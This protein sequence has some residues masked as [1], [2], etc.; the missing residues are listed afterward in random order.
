VTGSVSQAFVPFNLAHNL[1]IFITIAVC[2]I[3]FKWSKFLNPKDQF[4]LR[5]LIAGL[6]ILQIV[7]FNVY[8]IFTNS[9]D[10]RFHLP[11][12]LCSISAYLTAIALLLNRPK[13]N[14]MQF[15]LAPIGAS[16]GLLFPDTINLQN[17]PSFRF[18]EYFT[19][20]SL[21]IIG[22]C[23][24]LVNSKIIADFKN[25]V[26]ACFSMFG[27][28][29]TAFFANS[30]FDGN[31]FNLRFAPNTSFITY[32]GSNYIYFLIVIGYSLMFV[33]HLLLKEFWAKKT[34]L[35]QLKSQN[36][37]QIF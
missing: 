23:Y 31:Y 15:Y 32:L 21:I 27:L 34:S 26:Y 5:F 33:Q 9:F 10:L 1:V 25:F 4:R 19:S 29:I 28:L 37:M 24:L 8:Y 13:L 6:L 11:F 30:V 22:T 35:R 7:S 17:F 18:L 2:G 36:Q 12:H 14:T 16:V 20:H 3:I